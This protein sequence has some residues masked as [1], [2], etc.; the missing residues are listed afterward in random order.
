MLKILYN[1]HCLIYPDFGFGSAGT[2]TLGFLPGR[3]H[4]WAAWPLTL[5]LRVLYRKDNRNSLL[6]ICRTA[7]DCRYRPFWFVHCGYLA[8]ACDLCPTVAVIPS[9]RPSPDV[10]LFQGF[11]YS[12]IFVFFK[13]FCWVV[14]VHP[15]NPSTREAEAGWSLSSRTSWSTE[16]FPGQA[17]LHR[18]T[19]SWKRKRKKEKRSFFLPT[20]L[21]WVNV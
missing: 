16:Q 20:H 3:V 21:E 14:M 5:I 2:G 8:L 13:K 12:I 4:Y 1:H 17:G 15:F 10:T 18:T 7:V 6:L 9:S 11:L 19:L